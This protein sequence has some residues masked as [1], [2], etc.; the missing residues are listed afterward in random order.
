[1]KS[2]LKPLLLAGL[3][4]TAGFAA[5]AASGRDCGDMMG[6][7]GGMQHERI[8]KMDPAK[9][10]VRMDK[11][12][13]ALKAQLKITAAQESAWTAFTAAMKPAAGM[14]TNRPDPTE[15]QKLST[16]ER[17]DKMQSVHTQR[18]TDMN[19]A[20]TQR[21]D[22]TKV[23]YAMLSPAQKKVFD[24]NAL[25]RGGGHGGQHGMRDGQAPVQPKS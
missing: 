21:G 9:M 22:A 13:D 16:P 14:M 6:H 10:Q 1:M 11:R 20:M 12:F 4:A 15:M 23:F 18:M 2:I 19:A 7:G 5:L 25:Q 17:I 3:L 24:E 8:G